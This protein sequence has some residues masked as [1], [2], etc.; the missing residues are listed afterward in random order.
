MRDSGDQSSSVSIE[1]I[2]CS[3][4]SG[5]ESLTRDDIFS[6]SK[7]LTKVLAPKVSLPEEDI[8]RLSQRIFDESSH[9]KDHITLEDFKQVVSQN[10]QLHSLGDQATETILCCCLPAMYGVSTRIGF[11]TVPLYLYRDCHFSFFSI[12]LV[13]GLFQMMRLL[14]NWIIVREGTRMTKPLIFLALL[15]FICNAIFQDKTWC[16]WLFALTGFGE[17][18]VS[19]QHE[20]IL[21]SGRTNN[22][23][24]LRKQ[25][26]WVCFG[27]CVSFVVGGWVFEHL[28]FQWACSIGALCCIVQLIFFFILDIV[29]HH[30]SIFA[31]CAPFPMDLINLRSFAILKGSLLALSRVSEEELDPCALERAV[32]DMLHGAL[33]N[34]AHDR[35]LICQCVL[36]VMLE[37]S[38]PKEGLKDCI[39]DASGEFA[40]EHFGLVRRQDTNHCT[41][42]AGG[43]ERVPCVIHFLVVSQ[44]FIALCIGTFLGAGTI[45]YNIEYGKSSF[46]FGVSMGFGE[47][48]GMIISH[49][50]RH[51]FEQRE[52]ERYPLKPI[53]SVI[54][55]M[56]LISGVVFLFTTPV[57]AVAVSVQLIF[58][59]L[60]DLWTYL[61]NDAIQQIA[62]PSQYRSWQGK[63]QMLRRFGNAVAGL[64]APGLLGIW[65]PLPFFAASAA[66][67]CWSSLFMLVVLLRG[68]DLLSFETPSAG[69]GD[70]WRFRLDQVEWMK[71]G[72]LTDKQCGMLSA[73]MDNVFASMRQILRC[74]M[75]ST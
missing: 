13:V 27:A 66:L 41:S 45:Y 33:G 19:L 67:A 32:P 20:L 57:L 47:L 21:V 6:A 64:L 12:G 24:P 54:S 8:R 43:M 25:F 58:Q 55:V 50:M 1:D 74:L 52:E 56:I 22:N 68:R 49:K 48:L 15:G 11:V 60:N 18:I 10:N 4:K 16:P 30:K 3:F 75:T 34:I 23:P 59:V 17:V 39:E 61:V 37:S 69:L 7:S 26:S 31:P 36:Y 65:S 44:V 71:H 2:F 28:S 42:C 51:P 62:P 29:N 35:M 38:G 46:F 73:G 63:G 70:L 5:S 72:P 53:V 40:E 9:G 14:A